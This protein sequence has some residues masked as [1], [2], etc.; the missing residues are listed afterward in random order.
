MTFQNQLIGF[1]QFNFAVFIHYVIKSLIA[2]FFHE[3]VLSQLPNHDF[4]LLILGLVPHLLHKHLFRHFQKDTFA[5]C[6]DSKHLTHLA[7]AA[8]ESFMA[9]NRARSIL[10]NILILK[11]I[12]LMEA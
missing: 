6:H 2:Q 8:I 3:F 5:G 7:H 11:W 4:L 9:N 10:G 12:L 1:E